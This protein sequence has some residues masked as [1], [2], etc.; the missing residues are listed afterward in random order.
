MKQKADLLKATLHIPSPETFLFINILRLKRILAFT[1]SVTTVA[2][3]LDSDRAMHCDNPVWKC[4][5]HLEEKLHR[6]AREGEDDFNSTYSYYHS[7]GNSSLNKMEQHNSIVRHL[8]L[9]TYVAMLY[10]NISLCHLK[11]VCVWGGRVESPPMPPDPS[12]LSPNISQ[13]FPNSV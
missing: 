5:V 7:L 6:K 2:R 3:I 13:D 4:I 11:I 10:L 1:K 12:I 9:I 8:F